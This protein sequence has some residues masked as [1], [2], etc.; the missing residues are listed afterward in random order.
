MKNKV[1]KFET[2]SI[3]SQ[4]GDYDRLWAYGRAVKCSIRELSTVSIDAQKVN[5]TA[6]ESVELMFDLCV[7]VVLCVV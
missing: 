3:L 1:E 2:V 4:I 7:C 6:D 5:R